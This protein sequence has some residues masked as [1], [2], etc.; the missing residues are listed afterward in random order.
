VSCESDSRSGLDYAIAGFDALGVNG[1]FLKLDLAKAQDCLAKTNAATCDNVG[2]TGTDRKAIIDACS[3]AVEG[4][5]VIGGSCINDIECKSGSSC[6]AGKCAALLGAG[7]ACANASTGSYHNPCATRGLGDTGLY[8][9]GTCKA[10]EP[11]GATCT[12][13]EMCASGACSINGQCAAVYQDES[14]CGYYGVP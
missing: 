8:C 4:L 10:Q 12:Y 3:R 13:N 9:S 14:S 5:Q 7:A 11:I 6:Q 1:R 2:I